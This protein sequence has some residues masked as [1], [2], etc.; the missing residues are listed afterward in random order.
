L[1]VG[2]GTA[3]VAGLGLGT[4]YG[5]MATS[6]RNQSNDGP[7]NAADYC[8]GAGLSLRQ[9]AL[10]EA[11]ISTVAFIVGL[12]AGA[13]AVAAYALAPGS[14]SPTGLTVSPSPVGGGTGAILR[15]SF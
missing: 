6:H 10:S 7:C 13:G 9:Q 5:I 12:A 11:T 14:S 4:V 3:A 1:T 15:S 8:S 2:L